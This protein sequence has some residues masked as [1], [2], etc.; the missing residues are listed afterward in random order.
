[1]G[2]NLL[3]HHPPENRE[4]FT[5]LRA[6]E[7]SIKFDKARAGWSIVYIHYRLKFSRKFNPLY[8]D[9]FPTHI[10]TIYMELPT[11]Y[12]KGSPVEFSEL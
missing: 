4:E 1:M 11:V 2:R 3:Y 9:G 8:S 10:D 7:C 5:L 6:M 12:F